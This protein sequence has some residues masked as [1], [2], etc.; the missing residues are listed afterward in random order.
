V[1][2]TRRL[3]VQQAALTL[4]SVG[5][6]RYI[7]R[8]DSGVPIDLLKELQQPLTTDQYHRMIDAGI[9]GED[10]KV[11][12][13]HGMLIAR[14]PQGGPHARII[15]RLNGILVR[16]L[17]EAYDVRVQ[18]PLTLKPTSEP[19]PDFSIVAHGEEGSGSDHP[20]TA[21]LVIEV[22]RSS[23]RWDRKVKA[24]LYAR[25]GI[26]ELWL[27]DVNGRRIEVMR[28]PDSSAGVYRVSFVVGPDDPLS[29]GA[30]PGL[31]LTGRD[32]LA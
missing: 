14:A 11:E 25:A 1:I 30:L 4:P 27:I 15:Q 31:R 3:V 17:G 18:L 32:L 21:L 13:V 19:E 16:G 24:P 26:P 23:L 6:R 2:A 20:S 12:L 10:D 22:S 29:P 8:M 5:G 7:L 9:L 28:E